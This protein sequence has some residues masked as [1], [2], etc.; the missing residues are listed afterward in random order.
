MSKYILTFFLFFFC[1]HEVTHSQLWRRERKEIVFGAGATNFLGDLG[2]SPRIGSE[3]F[4]MR[5]LNWKSTRP[6]VHLG[7][8][9]RIDKNSAFKGSLSF[10][11][12]YGNDKFTKNDVRF[13]RNIN[14]R[15]PIWE[16]SG[17]YEFLITHQR[18]GHRYDL[19]GVQGWRYINVETYAFVGLGLFV[20]I[21]QGQYIDG[22]WH[23][24]RPLN[25]EG[26]GMVATRKNYSLIQ[27]VIP[28]GIGFKYAF[29]R[30]WSVGLEY[31]LRKTF[32]DY[33]DDTSTTYYNN[34]EIR[35]QRGDIAAYFADPSHGLISGQTSPGAQRG[36]VKD[37]DSYMFA[38]LTFYYKIPK[39]KGSFPKF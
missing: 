34:N 29:A 25:T 15:S 13:N 30:Y 20:F 37:K 31:G 32:T 9:Y 18:E 27:P 35:E 8:R 1:I 10:G 4:S 33:I 16:L 36:D 12:L 7:Y 3:P 11:Y 17:Q 28:I 2:G 14:F 38:I 24:L 19:R 5:D 6:M 39:G 26:Q 21:P 22:T 23:N